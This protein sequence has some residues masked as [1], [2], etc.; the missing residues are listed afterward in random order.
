M[1]ERTKTPLPKRS[2]TLGVNVIQ[3]SNTTTINV[4]TDGSP[5]FSRTVEGHITIGQAL[6]VIGTELQLEPTP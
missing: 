2:K 3:R 4:F 5:T 6:I 1:K